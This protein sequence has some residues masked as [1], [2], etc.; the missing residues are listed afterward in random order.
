MTTYLKQ[1]LCLLTFFTLVCR[2]CTKSLR[3]LCRVC[4]SL[5]T[6]SSRPLRSWRACSLRSWT[7]VSSLNLAVW[8][9]GK[10][11]LVKWVTVFYIMTKVTEP[12]V[13]TL[14]TTHSMSSLWKYQMIT[15]NKVNTVQIKYM[16]KLIMQI[17]IMCNNDVYHSYLWTIVIKFILLAFFSANPFSASE[18]DPHLKGPVATWWTG[19]YTINVIK[20]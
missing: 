1:S 15:S 17:K 20:F 6:V 2:S 13:K 10:Q 14:K 16:I 19:Q 5:A 12:S 18:P 3:K 7:V 8:G 4:S 9:G 11:M